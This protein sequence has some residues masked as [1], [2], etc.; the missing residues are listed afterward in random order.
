MQMKAA[1]NKIAIF[2]RVVSFIG[3]FQWTASI[4]HP[5]D[6]YGRNVSGTVSADQSQWQSVQ[7][8]GLHWVFSI[9]ARIV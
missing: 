7:T 3:F 1:I 5:D 8:L 4:Q 6:G 9:E 2:F